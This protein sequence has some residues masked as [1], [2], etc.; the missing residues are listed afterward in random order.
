MRFPLEKMPCFGFGLPTEE[1]FFPSISN[2]LVLIGKRPHWKPN[3]SFARWIAFPARR[4]QKSCVDFTL[5]NSK[6]GLPPLPFPYYT[7]LK[8]LWGWRRRLFSL[9]LSWVFPYSNSP[10]VRKGM[11]SPWKEQDVCIAPEKQRGDKQI[12]FSIEICGKLLREMLGELV[13]GIQYSMG[14]LHFLLLCTHAILL[15][16]LLHPPI[17]L[18]LPRWG[19]MHRL[20][21]PE[22]NDLETHLPTMVSST[23]LHYLFCKF[24]GPKSCNIIHISVNFVNTLIGDFLIVSFLC[25]A[26]GWGGRGRSPQAPLL[27][28]I[29]DPPPPTLAQCNFHRSLNMVAK[30]GEKEKEAWRPFVSRTA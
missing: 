5:K 24:F 19:R 29:T 2:E 15:W 4:K 21:F 9:P 22:R 28:P 25:A 3:V 10:P 6:I 18:S 13:I 8:D 17:S 27:P 12:L 26:I 11:S 16:Q 30:K 20:S 14:R 1:Y 23:F 7:G